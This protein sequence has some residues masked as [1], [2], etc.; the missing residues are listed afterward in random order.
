MSL[1]ISS[2]LLTL[3]QQGEGLTVEYKKSTRDI[4]KDVYETVCSFSNREGGHIFLGVKDD[5]TVLGIDP[6]CIERM[7]KD[8]VTSINNGKKMYPPLYTQPT[9]ID[10]D[11]KKIL[12]IYVPV[13]P[14]VCRC[15]GRIYD[16][17]NDA[18]IDIT[19]NEYLVYQLYA[20]KQDTYYVNKVFPVFSVSDLRADLIERAKMMACARVDKHLWKNMSSEELL[21]SAKLILTDPL[22]GK[23]GI[24]LASILLFGSDNLIASVLAHHKTDAI[25]RVYNTDRYDDRDVITTNLLDSYDRLMDFGKRH[26]NDVFTMDGIISVSSRDK[27]LREIVSNLLVH[28]D[29]SNGFVAKLVIEKDQLFTENANRPHGHGNLNLATFKPFSK[30]PPISSVFREIGLADE[31]GSGMRN[32]YKYTYL[33]SGAQPG[34]VEGDVFKTIIPLNAAATVAVGPSRET[35]VVGG[36]GVSDGVNSKVDGKHGQINYN[37]KISSDGVGDGVNESIEFDGPKINHKINKASDG[38]GDGAD[39]VIKLDGERLRKLLDFCKEERTRTE[40]MN[41]CEIRSDSYFRINILN[42]LLKTGVLKRTIPD[43]P[44][45]SKQKYVKG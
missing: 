20:R 6:D 43:K 45:S 3:L 42:P 5:G 30:N 29:F 11:G 34:F 19:D 36:A 15:A 10:F 7:K 8:F 12:Y 4:T 21:R 24:T 17:N 13:S 16:R 39:I 32:T 40:M 2:E 31:L 28:R 37:D 26:M 35:V 1:E 23:E 9:E 22:T 14:S 18:D 38:V 41:F 27:I 33:Y 25:L 44:N